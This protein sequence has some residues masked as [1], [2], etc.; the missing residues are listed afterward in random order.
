ML[1]RK[2]LTI[3][4]AL[5]FWLSACESN[6]IGLEKT[7]IYFSLQNFIQIQENR[8]DSIKPKVNKTIFQKGAKESKTLQIKSWNYELRVFKEANINKAIYK[9]MYEVKDSL[10]S[11]SLFRIHSAKN[12]DFHTQILTVE[13]D[14]NQKKVKSIF[15]FFKKDDFLFQSERRIYL[16][17]NQGNLA[18]YH[19]K[20]F[21]KGLFNSLT[22]Y[23]TQVVIL[24]E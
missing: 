7:N 16:T 13:F 18:S 15:V 20:G 21:Q 23:E 10:T 6:K 5:F 14:K 4:F 3:I 17:C 24:D 9:D 11:A 12:K 2:L 19:I 1:K 8:L 22:K